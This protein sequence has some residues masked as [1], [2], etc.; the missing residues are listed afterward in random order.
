VTD[1]NAVRPVRVGLEIASALAKLFP[2]KFE[3]D[4][5]L[6]LFG[7]AANLNRIKASEDPSAIAAS[8]SAAEAHWRLLRAKY[9]L[10]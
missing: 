6:R 2:G 7:S 9:L 4:A 1:R 10:Y 3:V 8:W 5:A